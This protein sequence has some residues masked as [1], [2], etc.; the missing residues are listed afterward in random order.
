MISFL[1][2]ILLNIFTTDETFHT[3]ISSSPDLLVA[4]FLPI[5]IFESAYRIEYHA[6]MK[7][8][9]FIL[10]LSICGYFI[11]LLSISILNKY[12][13]YFQHWT[14]VQCLILGIILSVTRPV[15]LMHPLDYGKTKRLNIILEGETVINTC[16]G[17]IL[18][19]AAKTYAVVN[20]HVLLANQFFQSTILTLIGGIGLGVIAGILEIIGLPY[21]YD[22]P[23]GEVTITITVPYILYWLC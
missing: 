6:F 10:L 5:L 1:G 23:I 17:I 8:L 7:S 9:Y 15:T 19:N 11:S 12:L 20:N 13:F 16:L 21:F 22:D 4:M 2:G 3:I 18:F 14:F